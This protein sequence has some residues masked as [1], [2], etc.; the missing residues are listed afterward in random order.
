MQDLVEHAVE[1][2]T[3]EKLEALL[4][5]VAEKG[6]RVIHI[7]HVG[8]RDWVVVS[9]RPVAQGGGTYAVTYNSAYVPPTR[10]AVVGETVR[11]LKLKVGAYGEETRSIGPDGVAKPL[12][13]SFAGYIEDESASWI[14]F[15]DGLGRPAV[16]WPNRDADGGVVGDPIDLSTTAVD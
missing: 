13:H 16:Y 11:S 9:A 12:S 4:N 2:A 15:L 8:G 1:R 14:V 3:T 5:D 10:D 7:E 6:R